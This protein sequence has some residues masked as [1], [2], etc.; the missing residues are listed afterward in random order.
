MRNV[1]HVTYAAQ[2]SYF[3]PPHDLFL[4]LTKKFCYLNTKLRQFHNVNHLLKRLP[5]I[6]RYLV[7]QHEM[8]RSVRKQCW[9]LTTWDEDRLKNTE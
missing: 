2:H 1:H 5:D 6:I 4:N 8:Q 9:Y 3:K 7:H